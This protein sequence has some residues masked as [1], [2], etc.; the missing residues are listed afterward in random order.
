MIV[1]AL[2]LCALPDLEIKELHMRVDTGAKTSSLHVDNI[3]EK[4]VEGVK[5]VSFNIHPDYHDVD[6]VVKRKAKVK[7]L[8]KIKTSNDFSE[9]RYVID[10]RIS[11]GDQSWKIELTLTDRSNMSYLML[12]GREAMKGR[13]IVDPEKEYALSKGK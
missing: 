8:R 11:I 7:A 2:E 3:S 1:G 12:L 6:K 10:T 9:N 4:L 13:L 5:W